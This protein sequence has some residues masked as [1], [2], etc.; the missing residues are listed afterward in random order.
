[1]IDEL[2]ELYEY[3]GLGYEE[4]SDIAVP[5]G[6]NGAWLQKGKKVQSVINKIHII[7][8]SG[9]YP[10]ME[11]D[12]PRNSNWFE[13]KTVTDL[14]KME[15]MGA[16]QYDIEDFLYCKYIGVPINRLI[17]LR[18]F[19]YPCTDNIFEKEIQSQPDIARMVT[20]STNEVNK[21]DELLSLSYGFRWKEL[22]AETEQASME[23]DQSGLSGFMKTVG[24]VMDSTLNANAVSGRSTGGPMANYNP[25]H[26]QNR[27]YG[28]VDSINQTNIR[29]IGLEFQ[30]E[31]E[32]TFDYELRSIGG[33]TAEVA[34]KDI[35]G[36]VLAC[37]FQNAKFWGGARFWVGERPTNF[38]RKIAYLNSD[39]VDE[40][41]MKATS[42]IKA[43]LKQ[44]FGSKES[45]LNTL[46]RALRGGFAVAIGKI[47]DS[48]GRP[49][50][51]TMNSLLSGEPT[52]FWHL[53]IGNPTNPIMCIGNLILT[54]VD[55][56]FPSDTLSYGDFPTKLQVVVKVKPGMPKDRA[57]IE[58]MFNHGIQRLYWAPKSVKRNKTKSVKRKYRSF[59]DYVANEV[60]S[61][62]ERAYDFVEGNVKAEGG[63]VNS[64]TQTSIKKPSIGNVS[65][66][67]GIKA[68]KLK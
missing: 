37:T 31:F 9:N 33:K 5:K 44:F 27:V 25:T 3:A 45:A 58:M 11:K 43:G 62:A 59:F 16:N 51:L 61:M 46:K 13:A 23:G 24:T 67:S 54:G 7:K 2:Q 6:V 34:F 48:V 47:L 26:D 40:I 38:A 68:S 28:P 14:C 57:G 52:G 50:I 8:L 53:T 41:L 30:K 21:F 64:I 63:A 49:G 32:I 1:M 36:N 4:S 56:K 39:N 22:T 35:I 12:I 18:R 55:L 15:G 10:A 17:T 19:P 60:S 29:D 42:Q 65:K 66:P 20:Y